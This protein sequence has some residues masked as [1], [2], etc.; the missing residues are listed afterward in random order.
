MRERVVE[1]LDPIPRRMVKARRKMKHSTAH[2]Q[3]IARAEV[4]AERT[5]ILDA[6]GRFS[7]GRLLDSSAQVASAL[8]DGLTIFTNNGSL[9]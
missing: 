4:H 2:P 1:L 6:E 8:L 3:L 9:S 7:Y 5:A